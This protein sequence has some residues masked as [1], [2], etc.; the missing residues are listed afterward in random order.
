MAGTEAL[1]PQ[2]STRTE[3]ESIMSQVGVDVRLDDNEDD[4]VTEA[5]PQQPDIPDEEGHLTDAIDEATDIVNEYALPLYSDTVLCASRWVR[6][7]ASYL[8]A[9]IVSQR[10]GNAALYEERACRIME[11]LERV[12]QG[13]LLIPRAER[14]VSTMPR[15]SNVRIDRR[16]IR[17]KVRVVRETSVGKGYPGQHVDH[18]LHAGYGYG[19]SASQGDGNTPDPPPEPPPE[20][21]G[22]GE[23]AIGIDFVVG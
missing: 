5:N 10:R 12:R 23:A 17:E 7:R 19:V 14:R 18:G 4:E 8:A 21:K 6:R 11:E 16:Y 13:V 20:G 9:W 1:P 2:Y 15:M 22:I 3:V